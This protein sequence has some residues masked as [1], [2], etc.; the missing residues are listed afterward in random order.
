M[1]FAT[2]EAKIEDE[3]DP[4][5]A[6]AR[7]WDDGIIDPRKTRDVVGIGLSAAA[8]MESPVRLRGVSSAIDAGLLT[9][10]VRA[11]HARSSMR[12]KTSAIRVLTAWPD[13]GTAVPGADDPF[14]EKEFRK[15]FRKR[16]CKRGT[17]DRQNAG[18]RP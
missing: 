8:E 11:T 3:S 18:R 15:E 16:V 2:P 10:C 1:S 13:N 9:F 17:P 5:F 6:T 7:L 14:R 12:T 4:F